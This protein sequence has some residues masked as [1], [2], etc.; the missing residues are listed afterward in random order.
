MRL[1][2]TRRVSLE[3]LYWL[4]K[5]LLALLDA[6]TAHALTLRGLG[7]LGASRGVGVP[8]GEPVDIAGLYFPNRVGLAAGFDKNGEAIVGLS[9]LGFGFIEI[10][11]VTPVGQSGNPKP[12][13][14]RI[15]GSKAVINRMGFNNDGAERMRTRME[16]TPSIRPQMLG[17]NLGMNRDTPIERALDD[18]RSSANLLRPFADFFT[19]NVS[20]PNTPQARAL[21]SHSGFDEILTQFVAENNTLKNAN[22]ERTRLFVKVSPDTDPVLL[23]ELAMRIRSSGC[24]GVVAT[25]TTVERFGLESRVANQSGGLSG[26]PLFKLSL[27][28]VELCRDAVGEGYP[29][30][31]VGGVS[32][33]QDA[34]DMRR[35]GADLIQLYTGLVYRGPSLVKELVAA[36]R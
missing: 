28:C 20:S 31:G 27:Q 29:I 34:I 3:V 15:A 26:K 25:N 36:L 33:A 17:V 9:R 16:A 8:R 10:G 24:D 14:F 18:F 7:W 2:T 22:G 32:S 23:R 1:T 13:L 35:A 6:E 21:Q 12:R 4:T 30:I 19:L 11:A 5:P